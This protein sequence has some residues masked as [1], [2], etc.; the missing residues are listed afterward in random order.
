MH[1]LESYS[2]ISGVKIKKPFIEEH[3]IDIPDSPYITFHPYD[4][5]GTAKRYDRWQNVLLMLKSN[6]IFKYKIVMIGSVVD[7]QYMIDYDY[8]GKTTYNSLAYLIKNAHMH[9]GFDSLPVHFASY[10]DKKIVA[11]YSHYASNCGPYF[12]SS[13]NIKIIEPDFSKIKPSFQ[14]NDP[15]GLINNILPETIYNSIMSLIT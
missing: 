7:K 10:Y 12:S 6:P 14:Y 1:I 5:K 11:I 9:V 15:F 4:P 8:I 2:L 3:P 13:E